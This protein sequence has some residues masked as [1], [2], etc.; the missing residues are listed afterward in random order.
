[1]VV[2]QF[3]VGLNLG[4]INDCDAVRQVKYMIKVERSHL[5]NTRG[6]SL[7]QWRMGFRF[8]SI[9]HMKSKT[10]LYTYAAET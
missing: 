6:V 8:V 2:S 1:M 10:S 5:Y 3:P 9:S 4:I 7:Q